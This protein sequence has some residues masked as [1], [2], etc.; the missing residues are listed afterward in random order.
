[1]RP[2]PFPSLL[3]QGLALG[4]LL[5]PLAVQAATITQSSSKRTDDNISSIDSSANG[6]AVTS[7]SI[8][9]SGNSDATFGSFNKFN[10]A[11][12]VLTGVAA[13]LDTTGTF[14]VQTNNAYG[15]GTLNAV[16]TLFDSTSTLTAASLSRL[17]GNDTVTSSLTSFSTLSRNILPTDLNSYVGAGT[18]TGTSSVKY[19]VTANQTIDNGS[20]QSL[21][22]R[23]S[24]PLTG[25]NTTQTLDYTYLLHAVPSLSSSSTQTELTIDFGDVTQNSYAD[26]SFSIYNQAGDRIALDLG[27]VMG[28]G[29][30]S[31]FNTTAWDSNLDMSG[32]AAGNSHL[33]GLTINTSALGTFSARYVLSLTD[34]AVGLSSYASNTLLD[35]ASLVV[36]LQGTVVAPSA[37]VP[38]P[39]TLALLGIGLVGLGRTRR[40]FVVA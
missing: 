32:L 25:N 4:L 28:S 38:E 19:T 39:A 33:F 15:T 24:R 1:M 36:W 2:A 21:T 17:S 9:D 40:R 29:D 20:S 35:T 3:S 6:S 5:L 7:S 10:S 11:T 34:S 12:G 37:G 13:E 16:W 27:S 30:T 26:R 31:V 23:Y 8:I 18:L 22:S 14:S